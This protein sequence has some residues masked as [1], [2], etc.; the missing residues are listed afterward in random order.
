MKQSF[1]ALVQINSFIEGVGR[2]LIGDAPTLFVAENRWSKYVI[3]SPIMI[4]EVF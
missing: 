2:A 4:S 3:F 1:N